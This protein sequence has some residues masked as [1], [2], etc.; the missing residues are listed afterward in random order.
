MLLSATRSWAELSLFPRCGSLRLAASHSLADAMLNYFKRISPEEALQ[1]HTEGLHAT[2]AALT[3]A[4][5]ER[6]R[7]TA[8]TVASRRGPGRPKKEPNAADV[9]MAAA[10]LTGA[11]ETSEESAAKR[12]KYTNWFASPFIRDILAAHAECDRSAKKTVQHLQ[13]T[14]QRIDPERYALL[15]ESTIRSWHDKDGELLPRFRALLD[16]GAGAAPRGWHEQRAFS[17]H[18][19]I[20]QG[21]VSALRLMREK[22]SVVNIAV[23]RLVMR[24]VIQRSQPAL[25]AELK[26]S[27]AFVSRWAHEQMGYS[28]RART[29]AAS[30]LPADW[31]ELGAA[32]AKR[33]AVAMQLYKVHPALIVN[34]DQTGVHLCP[35]DKFTYAV[36]GSKSVSVIGAEDK[37]QITAVVA[38]SLSG[39]L[40]PL[41]LIFQGKTD[42]CHPPLTDA[43][44]GC[45]FHLTHSENHWSNV[46]TMQQ[47]VEHVLLPYCERQI[48]AHNLPYDSHIILQLDAWKVHTNG[49]FPDWLKAH[50]KRIH[51][52]YVPAN[53]TSELQ[54]AD[55]ILQRPFKCGLRKRF[56]D[57]AADLIQEQITQNNVIGLSPYLKMSLIKPR[58]LQWCLDSWKRL[59]EG[60]GRDYIKF[61]WHRCCRSLFDVLD[62][63]K[64]AQAVEEDALRRAEGH[65]DAPIVSEEQQGT[66]EGEWDEADTD[67]EK[68][69]LDI[70]KE[71][72]QPSRVQPQRESRKRGRVKRFGGGVDPTRIEIDE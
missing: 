8:A 20:E 52:L 29:T 63:I 68:D 32:A 33:I 16:D 24:A 71:R 13:R 2:G 41:Q 64:R 38:S 14:H 67:D 49:D 60:N 12:G 43:V 46:Q 34:A 40:L 4:A 10:E 51:V 66:N 19:E 11:E 56:N 47:W 6:Q 59:Q 23:I 65:V 35:S 44:L 21:I 9:L 15:S 69:E 30:K 36:T 62:P 61:G 70:M 28:W 72:A 1:Q 7:S 22:G 55:V 3:A 27:S 48:A 42:A 58:V 17:G 26:L 31:R 50:H 25:L 54:V 37:R 18:E 39:D 57:W 53:C 5:A 45:R